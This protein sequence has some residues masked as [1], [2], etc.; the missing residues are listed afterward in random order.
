[1]SDDLPHLLLYIGGIESPDYRA[2]HNI[3]S[4]EYHQQR[5]RLLR[6]NEE[7]DTLLKR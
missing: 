1:M 6:G 3:I 5:P 2:D 7:Y 4:P